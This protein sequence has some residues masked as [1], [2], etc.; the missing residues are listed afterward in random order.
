MRTCNRF[1]ADNRRS[2]LNNTD[3]SIISNNCWGGSVYRHYGI[4]YLSPT[5]GLYIW[6]TDYVKFCS[7]LKSY[8]SKSLE[9]IPYTESK[10]RE[11]LEHKKEGHVPIA[12]LGDDVE[13]VFLHYKTQEEAA[14]KW[15][16]RAS[17]INYNNLIFKFSKLDSCSYE[18]LKAFDLLDC[19]KKFCFLP[20]VDVAKVKSGIPFKRTKTNKKGDI[21]VCHE[22]LGYA[23][24]INLNKMINSKIVCGVRMEGTYLE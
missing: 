6:P 21:E 3:F 14:E 23:R 11:E 12:R 20:T 15:Y 13:I 1:L 10:Y 16:R 5:V 17:R 19:R 18:N 22:T 4:P 7:N 9:F 8:M 24:S 2:K